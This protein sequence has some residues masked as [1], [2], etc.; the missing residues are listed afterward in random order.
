MSYLSLYRQWRP[1]TF[2]DIVGQDHIVRTLRNAIA[3]GRVVHAYMFSGPRGTGKTST[4]KVLAKALNCVEG[5]TVK[6]CGVCTSCV[7][8]KEGNALDVIEIDAASNRGI[9]EIR[10]LRDKV[11]F[12]P[13][14]GRYKV[15]I[16]DEVHMLTMEA[17]NALLKTLEEPPAHAIF[18]LATTEANRVPAT[19]LSRC[20]RFDFNRLNLVQLTQHLSKVSDQMGIEYEKDALALLARK[21]EGSARDALGLLEQVSSLQERITPDL[22]SSMLGATGFERLAEI[23]DAISKSDVSSLFPL[24]SDAL[25]SG[26]DPRQL[27]GEMGEHFMDLMLAKECPD[28]KDLLH[29]GEDRYEQLRKASASF[30]LER[31]Q[32]IVSDIGIGL[33]EIGKSP[34]PRLALELFLARVLEGGHAR[35]GNVKPSVSPTSRPEPHRKPATSSP[36]KEAG[37]VPIKAEASPAAEVSHTEN[38]GIE[39]DREAQLKDEAGAGVPSFWGKLLEELK[40]R[41]IKTEALARQGK[42][43]FDGR[44][45][46]LEYPS[47]WFFHQQRMQDEANSAL[48][49]DVLKAV[50]GEDIGYICVLLGNEGAS[51]AGT[52]P[53]QRDMKIEE[54]QDG[55]AKRKADKG[56]DSAK[57]ADK[58]EAADKEN[59]VKESLELAKAIFGEVEIKLEEE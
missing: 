51:N 24:V 31:L 43:A 27:L 30:T 46:K 11:R 1:Q 33:A 19:I 8:V 3:N 20:Q 13:A 42:P 54:A 48:M 9:D 21:A 55:K 4:A 57:K 58:G 10:D 25:M 35:E 17:F 38:D 28:R 15:Y 34:N 6:P 7:A 52:K 47:N 36:R 29:S 16:I 39:Q 59:K 12:S 23:A 14:Q 41:S 22:I 5:P 56:T 45:L 18:V 50:T 40:N 44:T 2:E 49:R 37:Q 53:A 26:T 32:R